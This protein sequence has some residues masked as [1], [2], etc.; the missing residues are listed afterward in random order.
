MT[1]EPA[2]FIVQIWRNGG[3]RASLRAV[4]E[5]EPRWFSAPEPLAR[6]LADAEPPRLPTPKDDDR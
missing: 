6:F 4:D 1:D 5:A 2:F 3:F